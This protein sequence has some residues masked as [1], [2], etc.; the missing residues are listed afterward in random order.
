MIRRVITLL[1]VMVGVVVT[2]AVQPKVS[3][4]VRLAP[5]PAARQATI[6]VYQCFHVYAPYQSYSTPDDCRSGYVR[7]TLDDN[8]AQVLTVTNWRKARTYAL[9]NGFRLVEGHWVHRWGPWIAR[10]GAGG[11]ANPGRKIEG[12]ALTPQGSYGFQFMFGVRANPGVHFPWRHAY[13]SDYWDD[14]PGSS[15][16]NLWT[17]INRHNAGRN[18][19]P[20]HNVP[21]YNYAAVIG[22]NLARV[23]GAGSAIF[24]HVGDGEATGGCVSLPQAKLLPII[25]WLRPGR[26][27]VITM[28]VLRRGSRR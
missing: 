14:D 25:R 3:A 19:E 15:R 17:D 23:P 22:Y 9:F 27:P 11:F 18:P 7:A 4:A 5:P 2:G 16:Y 24:L 21:A 20:M 26:D 28:R 13:R 1:A 8:T 10:I 12:D 6:S